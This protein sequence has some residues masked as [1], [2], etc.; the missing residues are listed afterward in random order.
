MYH[1]RIHLGCVFILLCFLVYEKYSLVI[2]S[3]NDFIIDT[4][5]SLHEHKTQTIH[6]RNHYTTQ[7]LDNLS[8]TPF[9][10]ILND[11]TLVLSK[12]SSSK[13]LKIS[14]KHPNI[15]NSI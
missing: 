1:L 14:S 5:F 8:Y 4:L 6:H 13:R 10:F 3:D 15:P 2:Y 12:S 11:L 7:S 9:M